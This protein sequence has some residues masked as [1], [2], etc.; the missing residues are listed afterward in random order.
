MSKN[1]LE[2]LLPQM[3]EVV[4]WWVCVFAKMSNSLKDF[5][6]LLV[7]VYRGTFTEVGSHGNL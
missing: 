5:V 7:I 1:F 4:K 3:Q 2:K 6:N